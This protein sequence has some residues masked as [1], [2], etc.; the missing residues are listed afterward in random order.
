MKKLNHLLLITALCS[1]TFFSFKQADPLKEGVVE[2]SITFSDLTPEL[3]QAESMLPS[4]MTMYFKGQNFRSEMPSAMGNTITINNDAKKEF[5]LIMDMM[6]QKT[7]MKQTEAE[8]K[9]QQEEANIKD[10]K[11]IQTKET[12]TIAGYLCKKATITFTVD[13]KTEQMDCFYTSDLPDAANR[14]TSPGFDQIKGFMME[15]SLNM[16][17]LKMKLSATKVK[18]EKVDNKLFEIPEGYQIKTLEELKGLGEEH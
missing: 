8:M 1:I 2:F 3:K 7:A 17:G 18:A 6:G 5:Y 11:V 13:G 9:K 15:Y 4:K 14:N 16:Q 10:I 12:K